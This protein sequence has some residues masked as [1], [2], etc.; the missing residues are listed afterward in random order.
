MLKTGEEFSNIDK[1]IH[2]NDVIKYLRA[3]KKF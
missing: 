3:Y 2:I 1:K